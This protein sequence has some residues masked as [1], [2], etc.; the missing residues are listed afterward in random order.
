MNREVVAGDMKYR[1]KA[2]HSVLTVILGIA[3]SGVNRRGMN[4]GKLVTYKVSVH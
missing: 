1:P 4:E 2:D 3:V